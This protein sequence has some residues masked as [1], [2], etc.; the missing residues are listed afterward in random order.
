MTARIRLAAVCCALGVVVT[1][2]GQWKGVDSL[3]LPGTQ[4]R[5]PGSFTVK[6]Q[7]PNVTAIE[8]NSRV[9]VADVNVGTITRIER[10]GWHALV[11]VR[12]NGTV[13]LPEN[14]TAKIGQTSLLGSQHIELAPPVGEPPTGHLHN[15]DLIPLSRA[16]QYPTTEQT[17]AAL[18]VVLN[19]GGIGQLQQI[20]TELNRALSGRES[21]VHDLLGQLATFT[22]SLNKQK[23]DIIAAMAGLDHLAST[24]GSQT[25][26]LSHALDAI[27]PA[28]VELN[29][30]RDNLL[31]ATISVGDFAATADK[32]VTESRDDTVENLRNLQPVLQGLSNAGRALTRSL[33]LYATFPWPE[34][35]LEKWIRG[36]YANLSA[37]I[38]LTLG[39]IDNSMLQGTPFEGQLTALE[40]ALGRTKDRQPGLGTPNPLSAPIL[41]GGR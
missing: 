14:V 3:P 27:P 1:G 15:G 10:Q 28:L 23:S 18:S 39:R 12:L 32:V 4:G 26:V 20:E 31:S 36:D 17:L 7:M 5:G 30:Q 35:N 38:D 21:D 40:T 9:R 22:D 33:G 34:R 8:D 6:I 29:K 41:Q 2:C 25:T 11:T 13:D 37:T 16:G 24:I 19:G